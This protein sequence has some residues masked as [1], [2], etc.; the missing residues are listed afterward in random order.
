VRCGGHAGD[1]LIT[2]A[3]AAAPSADA[4]GR[5]CST[6][7]STTTRWT[8]RRIGVAADGAD[9]GGNFAC[10]SAAGNATK[11]PL[12]SCVAPNDAQ[13]SGRL[14]FT[15]ILTG[16]EGGAFASTSVPTSQA[17]T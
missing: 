15:S 14:R 9:G 5:S 3:I 17:W 13:G 11:N 2:V 8:A 6:S 7:R 1:G 16:Q 12:A 10:L 4:A